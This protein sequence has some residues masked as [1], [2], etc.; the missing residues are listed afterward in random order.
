MPRP[1]GASLLVFE[2]PASSATLRLLALAE[3]E[4][5]AL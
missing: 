5:Q 3:G 1:A 2:P 4:R